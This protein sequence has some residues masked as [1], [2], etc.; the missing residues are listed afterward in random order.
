MVDFT[1]I[2]Y[3]EA[4]IFFPVHTFTV[5]K[6]VSPLEL[7]AKLKKYI[8]ELTLKEQTGQIPRMPGYWVFSLES[9]LLTHL[10]LYKM[11]FAYG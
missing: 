5:I 11:H 3:K 8:Y 10:F 4:N 1:S 6:L 7:I 2:F 9:K